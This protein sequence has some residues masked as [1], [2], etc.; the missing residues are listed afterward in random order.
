[1]WA[2]FKQYREHVLEDVLKE[3]IARHLYDE[4]KLPLERII[5]ASISWECKGFRRLKS[6][7]MMRKRR[8]CLGERN[9]L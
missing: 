4:K 9:L 8:K 5:L 1:M 7:I 6:A 3:L 2:T